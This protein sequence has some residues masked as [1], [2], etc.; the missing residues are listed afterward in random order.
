MFLLW[1]KNHCNHFLGF[2][3]PKPCRKERWFLGVGNPQLLSYHSKLEAEA[4]WGPASVRI[5]R[6]RIGEH[7]PF[8]WSPL[9]DSRLLAVSLPVLC[10]GP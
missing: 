6:T 1:L 10:S 3:T 8:A 5:Q 9:W 2:L 7:W 4:S